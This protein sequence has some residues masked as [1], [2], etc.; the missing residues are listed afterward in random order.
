MKKGHF[1][2]KKDVFCIKGDSGRTEKVLKYSLKEVFIMKRFKRE[3]LIKLKSFRERVI[4]L[5]G[6]TWK[7]SRRKFCD[8]SEIG[9]TTFYKIWNGEK[10]E[11][12]DFV[13]DKYAR[14]F[15]VSFDFLKYGGDDAGHYYEVFERHS[16]VCE[17][18]PM[19]AASSS[20]KKVRTFT[21][22]NANIII[23]TNDP[24]GLLEVLM[25]IKYKDMEF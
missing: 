4:Y 18:E 5:F 17:N 11:V 3:E 22:G 9:K 8:A 20:R 16:R 13:I 14:A 2:T 7:E 1:W 24:E 19:Y 23:T 10:K 15:D 25:R 6:K 12:S 21:L